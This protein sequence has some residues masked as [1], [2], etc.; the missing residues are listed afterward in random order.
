VRQEGRENRPL[1]IQRTPA[2][3]GATRRAL[4][5]CWQGVWYSGGVVPSTRR[6]LSDGMRWPHPTAI[7]MPEFEL[8]ALSFGAGRAKRTEDPALDTD[9]MQ[10]MAGGDES[11]IGALYDRWVDTVNALVTHIVADPEDAEEVVASVFWQAWQQSARWSAEQGEPGGWLLA[12]ARSRSLERLRVLRR[13]RGEQP[14]DASLFEAV[15]GVNDP[16]SE[17]DASDRHE[18]VSVALRAVSAEQREVLQAAFFEGLRHT[19]MAERSALP[20]LTVQT[21][22][23]LGLRTFRDRLDALKEAQV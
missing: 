4:Q 17:L 23:R 9:I 21:R 6:D 10:R 1:R 22:V 15:P 8:H 13:R 18:R 5:K 12:I 19:E 3:G 11:A 20:C 7:H 16:L 14:M 2:R